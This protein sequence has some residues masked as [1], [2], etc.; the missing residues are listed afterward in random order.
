[1]CIDFAGYLARNHGKVLY[2]A[3]EEKLNATLQKELN[4]T[5]VK[6]PNLFVSNYL[7][8]D[9]SGYHFVFID[10]V[11]KMELQPSDLDP[12]K[13]NFPNVSFIYVFQ[14]TE[15]ENFRNSKHFQHDVGVVIE[16]PKKGKAVQN[17][18]LNQE[19]NWR[20]FNK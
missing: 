8:G 1:M 18:R 13:A 10:I 11:N 5:N 14:T 2:V 20:Y 15:E 12:L 3:K 7:P 17:S 16:I 6:H 4:D 9:L 19:G